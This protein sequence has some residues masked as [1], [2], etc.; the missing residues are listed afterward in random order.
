MRSDADNFYGDWLWRYS[1][2][3]KRVNPVMTWHVAELLEKSFSLHDFAAETTLEHPFPVRQLYNEV[4]RL[5][6]TVKR[7]G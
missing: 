6:P 2:D 7:E 4:L 5:G 1:T 3:A